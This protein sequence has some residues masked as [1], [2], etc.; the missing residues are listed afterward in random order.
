MEHLDS[1]PWYRRNVIYQIYPWSFKDSNGDGVGD[2]RGI[3]EKLDYLNDGHD[4]LNVG[5]IWLSPIYPS[6]MKDFGYDISDYYNIDPRFGNLNDFDEL[7]KKAHA[8]G[9]KIMMDLVTNHTSTEHPWFK[10]SRSSRNNPKRDW[11]IWHDPKPDGTPPNNWISVSGGSM[12]ELDEKTY[13]YYLHN[14]LPSQPDLNWRNK[15]VQE[16]MKRIFEFWI[17]RGVDGFR[18]DAASHFIEDGQFRDDPINLH[19]VEGKNSPYDRLLHTFSTNQPGIK[20]VIG[21]MCNVAEQNKEIFIVSEVYLG[22]EE[23]AK[24]YR[25]CNTPVHAPFNFSL[26]N[27]PWQAKEIRESIEA[28]EKTLEPQ[29]VPTY[30]LGNHDNSRIA[31]RRGPAQARASALLLLTLRGTPFIY[32]GEEL[33]MEDVGIPKNQLKDGFIETSDGV[34]SRDPERTPMQWD[35]TTHAGF[36]IGKPWLPVSKDYKILNVENQISDPHSMLN[37]Y[38][39]LINFRN[40]SDALLRGSYHSIQTKSPNV[41]AFIRE[42][43]KEKLL[44]FINF[45]SQIITEP[46]EF[47]VGRM[48]VSTH[49]DHMNLPVSHEITLRPYEACLVSL[50]NHKTVTRIK[51][52]KSSNKITKFVN[53][54]FNAFFIRYN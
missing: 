15:E 28:Y 22:L 31:T 47:V 6:P 2:L 18:V 34:Y 4:S 12:W 33:G 19:Y 43:E 54:I 17:K 14:F 35:D 1:L 32:Y 38:R 49:M 46:F 45:S 11:Y 40:N 29:D 5:A 39:T 44:I 24:F 27:L 53:K 16:E 26:L 3:I 21:L 41:F 10:E 30:V 50:T 52:N 9:L 8:R 42:S 13:Q 36:T 51:M 37:L 23:L 7:V 25:F 48:I 20:E